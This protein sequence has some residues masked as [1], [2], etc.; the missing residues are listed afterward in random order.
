MS[1]AQDMRYYDVEIVVIENLSEKQRNSENWPLQV[2]LTLPEKTV[3]LGQPVSAEWLPQ[4]TDLKS[5]YKVLK[6]ATYQLT[7]EVEKISE[8][9]TQRVIFHTAWRQPGLDKNLALP[10][11]FK[12]EV[13]APP[14]IEDENNLIQNNEEIFTLGTKRSAS[15]LEGILRVTLA[16]Y[17]H[18]EAE[19]T[20]R[21]KIPATTSSDNP[22]S[23]LD[24]EN[25]RNNIQKQGVIHLKQKRRRIRSNELHYL[26]HPVLGILIQITQY[27]KPDE[28]ANKIKKK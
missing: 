10:V 24:N 19:L 27:E 21:D 6:S 12:R 9:K 28:L 5:N 2:N 7:K 14:V 13:P 20:Y 18:L 8:S 23:I 3:Q 26:D 15:I 4:D 25:E 22:F 11:Y 1:F 17:L 16:R